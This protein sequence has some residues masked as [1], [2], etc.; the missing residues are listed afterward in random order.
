[1]ER[2]EGHV[3]FTRAMVIEPFPHFGRVQLHLRFPS[4]VRFVSQVGQRYDDVE[5]GP[6]PDPNPPSIYDCT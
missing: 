3:G 6:G 2:V 5:P 4:L 1:M